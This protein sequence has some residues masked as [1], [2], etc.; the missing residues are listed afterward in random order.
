[1]TP[2]IA[3]VVIIDFLKTMSQKLDEAGQIAKAAE[4]ALQ[5]DNLQQA[6]EI[7]MDVEPLMFDANTLLN[8]ACLLKLHF[9]RSTG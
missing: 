5:A 4:T 1:V 9:G 8:G 2:E 3:D 7:I 6:V